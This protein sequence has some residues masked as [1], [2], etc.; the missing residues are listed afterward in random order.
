MKKNILIA[1]LSAVTIMSISLAFYFKHKADRYRFY[2]ERLEGSSRV[3]EID[4]T[5]INAIEENRKVATTS[6]DSLHIKELNDIDKEV[7]SKK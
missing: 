5:E 2:I 7:K 6:E 1:V 4:A 3:I